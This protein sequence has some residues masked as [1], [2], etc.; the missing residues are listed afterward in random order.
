MILGETQ[1]AMLTFLFWNVGQKAISQLIAAA[2]LSVEADCVVL[3]ECSLN[4]SEVIESLNQRGPEYRYAFGEC[5]HVTFFTKFE[6]R[7][8]VPTFEN[9]RISIRRLNLPARKEILIA[10]AHLPSRLYFSEASLAQECYVLARF[11]E[12]EEEIVGHKRTV[13]VGDLNVNPF[14]SGVVGAGGL[15]AVS[16]RTIAHKGSRVVQK[17]QHH[18]FYN[19]MWSHFGDREDGPPGTHYYD[20]AESV[21]YFWNMYDQ[22][23]LRPELLDGFSSGS[24]RILTN[25]GAS[26]LVDLSGHPDKINASDHLPIVFG[27]NL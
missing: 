22:V 27:L 14:D 8:L 26:T 9:P 17:R 10:A 7:F 11:I 20:R 4:P 1:S 5:E 23:L 16:S 2:A 12:N 6:P 24:L 19:P 21:N 25:A 3:C 18:F 15:H 13:L